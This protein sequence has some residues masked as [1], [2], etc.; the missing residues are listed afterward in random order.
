MAAVISAEK[1]AE[2]EK[3]L[4]PA[5]PPAARATG[6]RLPA[7]THPSSP[8]ESDPETLAEWQGARATEPIPVGRWSTTAYG[9]P[10]FIREHPPSGSG[11]GGGAV[12]AEEA[13]AAKPPAGRAPR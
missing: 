9:Q 4:V 12:P 13:P 6:E 2:Q 1:A 7:G 10:V 3:D 11:G 8:I 5:P